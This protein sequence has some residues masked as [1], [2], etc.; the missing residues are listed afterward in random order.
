[1]QL[2]S[3]DLIFFFKLFFSHKKLKKPPSKVAQKNSNPLFSPSCLRCPNGPNKIIHVPNCGLQTN[4]IKNWD[5]LMFL[6]SYSFFLDIKDELRLRYQTDSFFFLMMMVVKAL[7]KYSDCL[8]EKF[9]RV[10]PKI[11]QPNLYVYPM[12]TG[13]QECLK[14]GGR[15]GWGEY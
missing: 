12:N 13:P 5:I 7:G 4:C 3:L 11:A 6:S 15:G 9:F 1:M 8:R 10:V 2:F 14:S